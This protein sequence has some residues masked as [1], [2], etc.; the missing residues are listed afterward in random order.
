MEKESKRREVVESFKWLDSLKEEKQK[1]NQTPKVMHSRDLLCSST[2][3]HTK[4]E[5]HKLC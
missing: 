3:L 5:I 2:L 1:L 4:K